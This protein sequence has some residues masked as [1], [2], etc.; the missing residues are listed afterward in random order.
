MLEQI[1]EISGRDPQSAQGGKGALW[2]RGKAA[3]SDASPREQ[4]RAPQLVRSESMA[5]N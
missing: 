4:F 1:S 3:D 5:L 2:R